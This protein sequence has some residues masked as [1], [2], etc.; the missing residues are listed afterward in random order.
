M[1]GL[2][3]GIQIINANDA[4]NDEEMKSFYLSSDNDKLSGHIAEF[5]KADMLIL[6]TNVEGVLD[7]DGRIIRIYNKKSKIKLGDKSSLGTGGMLSKVNVG[8]N[9]TKKGVKAI[10][11]NANSKDVIIKCLT[12]KTIGTTFED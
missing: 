8:L 11:A 7:E 9:I 10:I 3:Y 5:I 4:I 1:K 2:K 6:L 12:E